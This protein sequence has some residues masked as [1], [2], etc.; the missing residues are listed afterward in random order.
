MVDA[1]PVKYHTEAVLSSVTVLVVVCFDNVVAIVPL[2]SNYE[3][4]VV[5]LKPKLPLDPSTNIF[6]F[7]P[8][9]VTTKSLK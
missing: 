8:S 3:F 4:G 2:T 1:A 5:V 6:A 9:L 7:T